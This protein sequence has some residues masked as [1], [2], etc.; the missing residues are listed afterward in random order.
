[1]NDT[2][3]KIL[4]PIINLP[5]YKVPFYVVFIQF[6]IFSG[7]IYYLK[8]QDSILTQYESEPDID[9]STQC[10]PDIDISTQY[11]SE[12]NTSGK[13]ILTQYESKPDI[14]ISTQYK[15]ESNTSGKDISTQYE[16]ES[17]SSNEDTPYKMFSI[18]E[19][20]LSYF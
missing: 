7:Y 16:S 6:S 15:S 19:K 9:I 11:E 2:F 12:S 5:F 4:E 13:D 8:D 10:E 1:M 14:D 18:L 20:F 17:N 3:K